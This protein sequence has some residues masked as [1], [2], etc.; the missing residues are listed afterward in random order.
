M[1]IVS[2][3][4]GDNLAWNVKTCFLEKIRQKYF[5]M[6]SAENFTKHAKH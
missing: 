3:G 4:I 6:L 1:Q 2:I 5:S